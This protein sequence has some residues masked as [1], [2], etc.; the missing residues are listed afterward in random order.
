MLHL[1]LVGVALVVLGCIMVAVIRNDSA[2]AG[3]LAIAWVVLMLW[4]P[5]LLQA[6]SAAAATAW[7][8]KHILRLASEPAPETTSNPLPDSVTN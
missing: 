2:P 5:V 4:Q 7:A 1:F 3:T 8:A 6:L